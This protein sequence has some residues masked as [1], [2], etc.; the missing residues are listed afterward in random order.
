M[1][2][3]ELGKRAPAFTLQDQNGTKIALSDLA[4]EWVVLYFYPKDDT[5]GCTVEACEFTSELSSFEKLDATVLGCSPDS[6]ESHRKFIAK[7]ELKIKLLS[8]PDHAVM[9]KYGA[10]GEKNNYGKKTMGVIRST[11]LIDP[12]GRVAHHWATVK[13]AG[14]AEQVRA[15]LAELAG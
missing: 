5:P 12:A 2:K 11:V 7:H 13:A 1:D 4:G 10:W 8:D 9:D 3:L 14:H 15:K 6:P